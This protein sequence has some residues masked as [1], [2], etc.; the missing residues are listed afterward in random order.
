MPFGCLPRQTSV[1]HQ[2]VT[3]KSQASCCKFPPSTCYRFSFKLAAC[4]SAG[5]YIDHLETWQRYP[6]TAENSQKHDE[7]MKDLDDICI[8]KTTPG[9]SWTDSDSGPYRAPLPS[10]ALH[11][12]LFLHLHQSLFCPP[13]ICL[14]PQVLPRSFP[15]PSSGMA[16]YPHLY[17]I[18]LFKVWGSST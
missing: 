7:N 3:R 8:L 13:A 11:L 17:L 4:F 14:R 12:C 15:G 1:L 10:S 5:S 16:G 2:L 9:S 6:K 18:C